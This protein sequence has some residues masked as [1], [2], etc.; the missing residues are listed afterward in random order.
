MTDYWLQSELQ[1]GLE[2]NLRRVQGQL[3][4]ANAGKTMGAAGNTKALEQQKVT[5]E[6]QITSCQNQRTRAQVAA[7]QA[8]GIDPAQYA[9]GNL[10]V[11]F[12]PVALNVSSLVP[13]AAAYAQATGKESDPAALELEIK[14]LLVEMKDS[15]GKIQSS[16]DAYKLAAE[17]T[18][19]IASSFAMGEA[20]KAAWF[21][22]LSSEVSAKLDL[23]TATAEFTKQANSL[24]AL[25]GGWVSRTCNWFGQEMGSIYE[26][27]M[28]EAA[29]DAPSTV[30]EAVLPG[31]GKEGS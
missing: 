3:D 21:S 22:A 31:T 24:N 1:A 11:R 16:A 4:D 10:L 14:T 23:F 8:A 20:D 12:D 27:A 30:P 26:N 9:A 2:A 18:Q 6:G 17:Q 15:Y 19:S 25:T 13:T 28:K 5:L 7:K 29:Q